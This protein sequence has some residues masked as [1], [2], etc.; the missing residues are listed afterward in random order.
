MERK[1]I[2]EKCKLLREALE[3][4]CESIEPN[5]FNMLFMINITI[6]E[7][8]SKLGYYVPT[9]EIK[10]EIDQIFILSHKMYLIVTTISA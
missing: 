9:A 6:L 5:Q 8:I 4:Y 7:T 3:K 10:N 1:I 2:L